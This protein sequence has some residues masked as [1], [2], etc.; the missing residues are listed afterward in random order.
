[1]SRWRSLT[2]PWQIAFEL[3][4][5]AYLQRGSAPIGAVV[6]DDGGGIISRGA[7]DF[8]SSRLAHA[9]L[10]ALS[11]IPTGV[12]RSTLEI[13]S[14]LEPCPMCTGAIRMCQL[15]AV[16]FAALD[17]S[18]GS[19]AF[20]AAN[21]FMREFPCSVHPPSSRELELTVVALVV[22]FRIRTGH[23]RWREHWAGYHPQGSELG[24]RL[25]AENAHGAWLNSS[26]TAELIYEQLAS[27][28]SAA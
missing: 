18:A 28:Q 2:K 5:V 3:A 27:L 1:V 12:N 16:H 17:P 13:F 15:R 14:T 4:I 8:S 6:V 21:D 24:A 7:N 10:A 9:E 22:E 23:H 19:T 25:A 11:Q 26:A 20:L